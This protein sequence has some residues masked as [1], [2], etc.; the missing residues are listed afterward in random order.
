MFNIN[1]SEKKRKK[2]N[3]SC[4]QTKR[5]ISHTSVSLQLIHV[6][7]RSRV[8]SRT[9]PARLPKQL[10]AEKGPLDRGNNAVRQAVQ[11]KR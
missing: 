6:L 5:Q 7:K 2:K 3:G 4:T 9:R 10:A 11:V 8:V 1:A